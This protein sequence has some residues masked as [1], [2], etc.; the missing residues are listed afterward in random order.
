MMTPEQIQEYLILKEQQAYRA[1][2]EKQ[3]TYRYAIIAFFVT[4]LIC[5]GIYFIVPEVSIGASADNNS[6]AVA[7]STVGGDIN[8]GF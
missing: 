3:K 4:V 8:N 2:K 6:V 1:E 7:G 5:F